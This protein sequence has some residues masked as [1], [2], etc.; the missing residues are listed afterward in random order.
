MALPRDLSSNVVKLSEV[1]RLRRV[2]RILTTTGAIAA[3]VAGVLLVAA[4]FSV[5]R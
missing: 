4:L 5:L 2:S 3:L 1:R